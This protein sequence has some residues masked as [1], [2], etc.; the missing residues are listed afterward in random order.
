MEQGKG[1]YFSRIAKSH[2]YN[3]GWVYWSTGRFFVDSKPTLL[4]HF[5]KTRN[6]LTLFPAN[7]YFTHQ[8]TTVIWSLSFFSSCNLFYFS[9][10]FS[11]VML[12]DKWLRWF[13]FSERSQHVRLFFKEVFQFS[14]LKR[15][16]WLF[17]LYGPWLSCYSLICLD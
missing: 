13:L 4:Q 11:C 2:G 7:P 8:N 1:L 15:L 14:I 17:P 3:I 5:Q 12:I 6:I 16:F 9:F 10:L